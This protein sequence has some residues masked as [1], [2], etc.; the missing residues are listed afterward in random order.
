M[1]L[2]SGGRRSVLSYVTYIHRDAGCDNESS[3]VQTSQRRRPEAI[4]DAA[5]TAIWTLEIATYL[6]QK[7]HT[8]LQRQDEGNR[9]GKASLPTSLQRQRFALKDAHRLASRLSH[10]TV[11]SIGAIAYLGVVVLGMRSRAKQTLTSHPNCGL[12][13]STRSSNCSA[14][15]ASRQCRFSLDAAI[16]WTDDALEA[17]REGLRKRRW[18]RRRRMKKSWDRK[19][20]GRCD[21]HVE[22]HGIYDSDFY[23]LPEIETEIKSFKRYRERMERIILIQSSSNNGFDP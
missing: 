18:R 22:V 19:V 17:R 12:T 20:R 2:I 10:A 3:N 7:L 5:D 11:C 1:E 8:D 23:T 9:S 14:P 21:M 13:R 6:T 15:R 16:F 4:A